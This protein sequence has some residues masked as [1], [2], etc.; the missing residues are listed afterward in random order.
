MANKTLRDLGIKDNAFED[1]AFAL[2][3][4]QCKN[5]RHTVNIRN[6]NVDEDGEGL[7]YSQPLMPL[8]YIDYINVRDIFVSK[9][10]IDDDLIDIDV[11]IDWDFRLNFPFDEDEKKD[12]IPKKTSYRDI[13]DLEFLI[14]N[15]FNILIIDEGCTHTSIYTKNGKVGMIVDK[16]GYEITDSDTLNAV[17]VYL[18]S[19]KIL[20]MDLYGIDIKNPDISLGFEQDI[21]F[22]TQTPI[23]VDLMVE[24][25]KALLAEIKTEEA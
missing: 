9:N 17:D 11:I 13:I 22:I 7:Y 18:K 8:S 2:I 10:D 6:S 3:G 15:N 23:T 25:G 1:K 12:Y 19:G 20:D 24:E 14:K 4:V 21:Y 16:E 5:S